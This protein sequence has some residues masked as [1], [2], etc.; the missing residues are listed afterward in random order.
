[1]PSFAFV[2]LKEVYV[3]LEPVDLGKQGDV[4]LVFSEDIIGPAKKA[5]RKGFEA[6]FFFQFPNCA[7]FDALAI[8]EMAA[9]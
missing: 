6:R 9:G 8:F 4:M 3:S 7:S 1:M 5:E 2:R